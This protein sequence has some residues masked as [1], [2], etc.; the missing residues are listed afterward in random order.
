MWNKTNLKK[1][2]K[3]LAV[4]CKFKKELHEYLEKKTLSE[5]TIVISSILTHRNRFKCF[6][7]SPNTKLKTA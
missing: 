4:T 5:R 7:P 6:L 1:R 3:K 2:T